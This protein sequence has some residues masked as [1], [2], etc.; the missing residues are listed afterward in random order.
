MK[1]FADSK[2]FRVKKHLVKDCPGIPP[3]LKAQ[4]AVQYASEIQHYYKRKSNNVELDEHGHIVENGSDDESR[5]G[6]GNPMASA[7]KKRRSNP[8]SIAASPV[9]GSMENAAA[10]AA[11]VPVSHSSSAAEILAADISDPPVDPT[12]PAN[13]KANRSAI[14]RTSYAYPHQVRSLCR[15]GL[16]T[17]TTAGQAAG[18]AQGNIVILQGKDVAFDFLLFCQRNPKACPLITMLEAGKFQCDSAAGFNQHNVALLPSAQGSVAAASASNS[19]PASAAVANGDVANTSNAAP[20]PAAAPAN[21]GIEVIVAASAAAHVRTVDVR[22][23][24]PRYRVF[25]NGTMVEEVNNV[26]KEWRDDLYTFIIGCSFSFEDALL[27]AGLGVRHVE[28]KRNVPMYKTNVACTPAGRFSGNLVVSM[29]PYTPA[30]A[31]KA[32][33][34]TTRYPK[35]HGAPVH[36]GDPAALGIADINTPDYGDAPEIRPGEVCVFWAC[37]VTPQEV[38]LQS[39]TPFAITHAPGCMLCLDIKNDAL[40]L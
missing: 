3:P 21:N 28:L 17:G 34:I 1:L 18:Y 35:V 10:A 11:A 5:D 30:D 15:A 24:V 14:S 33:Q 9:G 31:V 37:G 4:L 32:T 38:I 8:A 16:Y 23:D 25:R 20:A 22:T 27:R 13:T 29:R 2:I 40:S 36:I 39:K 7:S 26:K 12:L 19:V 6:D